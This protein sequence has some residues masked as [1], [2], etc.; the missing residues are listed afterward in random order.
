MSNW[1]TVTVRVVVPPADLTRS[2]VTTVSGLIPSG[3]QTRG[4]PRPAIEVRVKNITVPTV[5][6]ANDVAMGES[7][8]RRLLVGGT[9]VSFS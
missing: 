5:Q 1:L 4:R 9:R 6:C 8:L 3:K 7:Y 2:E